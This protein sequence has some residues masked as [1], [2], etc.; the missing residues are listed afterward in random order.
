MLHELVDI[1]VVEL[2]SRTRAAVAAQGIDSVA[3]VRRAF[4]G[5]EGRPGRRLV[6][7]APEV[8]AGKRTLERFLFDRVYRSPRVLEV[9]VPAQRRLTALFR[10]YC[11]HPTEM[12]AGFRGRAATVGVQRSVGDYLAGMTDRYLEHDHDRRL[13]RG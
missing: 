5:D 9:R 1:Q 13:G 12:P 4:V 2:V 6:A 10:W 8:A 3:A 7:H 11:D